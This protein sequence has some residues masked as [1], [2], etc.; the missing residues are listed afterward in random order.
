[1][2]KDCYGMDSEEGLMRAREAARQEGA[3]CGS[4]AL[5]AL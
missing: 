3:S 1:M 5:R 2:K 4:F